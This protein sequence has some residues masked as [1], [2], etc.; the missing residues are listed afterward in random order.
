M[1]G[2]KKKTTI[3]SEIH[4]HWDR[5]WET[6]WDA[7]RLTEK[8]RDAARDRHALR[9]TDTDTQTHRD[10]D[11]HWET[12]TQTET[13][14]NCLTHWDTDTKT[15]TERDTDIKFPRFWKSSWSGNMSIKQVPEKVCSTTKILQKHFNKLVEV[16]DVS[17][18]LEHVSTRVSVT[19]DWQ[20][21]SWT[22]AGLICHDHLHT[23][24][25]AHNLLVYN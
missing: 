11:R 7:E 21:S 24:V 22:S 4:R 9:Q 12:E 23:R 1:V 20:L 16:I 18:T 17:Y 25:C 15:Q 6:Q 13:L 5:H 8:D 3:T 19:A 14:R 2:S 10:T